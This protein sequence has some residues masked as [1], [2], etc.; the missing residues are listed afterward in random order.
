M[1]NRGE[2]SR[3][4]ILEAATRLIAEKGFSAIT[5]Q[6]VLDAARVTKGKFFHHFKSKEDLFAQL[7]KYS[8]SAREFPNFKDVVKP[9]KSASPF[10]DLIFIL[11][12][13]IEWHKKGL[14]Q[15]MRLCVFATVF[16]AP[17]SPEIKEISRRLVANT[18][19]LK[20]L[21]KDC[22]TKKLL[23]KELDPAVLC[24]LFPSAGIGGNTVGFLTKTKDLTLRN[25]KELKKMLLQL[26]CNCERRRSV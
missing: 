24:L 20:K 4:R 1:A 8:L 9:N 5:V 10:E 6:D 17:D 15:V 26:N 7:L 2:Q 12:K 22:Q 19:V 18:Q 14:P 23:P 3:I 11:D 13:V 21:I 16:F 25:L